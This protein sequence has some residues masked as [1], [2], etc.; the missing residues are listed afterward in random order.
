MDEKDESL[1]ATTSE[2]AGQR[3][4]SELKGSAGGGENQSAEKGAQAV[5]GSVGMAI[6]RFRA[7]MSNRK[8]SILI[9]LLG[10]VSIAIGLSRT[11]GL[12]GALGFRPY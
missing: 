9:A 6:G 11:L 1:S 7:M 8:K 10:L 3:D 12:N 2:D 4:K 5:A